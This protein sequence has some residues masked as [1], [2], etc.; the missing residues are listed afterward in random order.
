MPGFFAKLAE[1]IEASI[2]PAATDTLPEGPEAI[3]NLGHW[4]DNLK[5]LSVELDGDL[6]KLQKLLDKFNR[7]IPEGAGSS[8]LVRMLQHGLP[9]VAEALTF[10]GIIKYEFDAAGLKQ[11]EID[12]ERIQILI[13]APETLFSDTLLNAKFHLSD[14]VEGAVNST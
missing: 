1:Y 5:D 11:H 9:Q 10:L 14:P 7:D 8:I 3:R 4:L 13:S 6:S 2:D 12:W